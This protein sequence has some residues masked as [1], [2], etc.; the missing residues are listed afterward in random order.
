[1]HGAVE[2]TG[3]LGDAVFVAIT[4]AFFALALAL[5]RA[6]ERIVGDDQPA[7]TAEAAPPASRAELEEAVR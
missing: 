7:P 1:M 2:L 4:V 5:L 3:L 6:C